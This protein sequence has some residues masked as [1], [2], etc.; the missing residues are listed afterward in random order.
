M[1]V[2]IKPWNKNDEERGPK[3]LTN[4]LAL[5]IILIKKAQLKNDQA[6]NSIIKKKN[7]FKLDNF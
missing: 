4:F 3:F 5:S 2:A 7:V 6:L 1:K